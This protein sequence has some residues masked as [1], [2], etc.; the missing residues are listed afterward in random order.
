MRYDFDRITDRRG[1][2]SV[3]WDRLGP[4]FGGQDVL[5]MWVADMDFPCPEPVIEA[6]RRRLEHPVLGYGFAPDSLYQ[7]IID[8]MRRWYGWTVEKDWIVFTPGVIAALH[9]AIRTVADP[10][11]EIVLQPPV[12]YPFFRAV[13]NAGCQLVMNRLR[14]GDNGYAMDYEA[15][16]R[17]F[18][19][20]AT[21]PGRS[22][23]IRG[24][25]LCSPHN[26][27]GRAWRPDELRRLG[28][29]CLDH[30]CV[31][32]S[33]EIHCD[34]LIGAGS[35]GAGGRP[36][37]TP[38]AT[39]SP[40]LARRTIT[41]MAPSKSF[42]LAGLDASFTIIPDPELRR[43]FGRARLG[44]GG[45]NVLG[46][47]AMEAALRDGDDYLE[48]LNDYLTGNVRRFA[49]GIAQVS[50]MRL[51]PDQ[52][53][54]GTYLAWV[55]LRQLGDR[56]LGAGDSGAAEPAARTEASEPDAPSARDRALWDFMLRRA[57]VASDPGYIFG[58]GGEGFQR[59]NLACPRSVVDEAITRLN[60]STPTGR[61]R[62]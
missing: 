46:L 24:L 42:N 13:K 8:R 40:E 18:E 54:E 55:D 1:T 31:I 28:Q 43:R 22:H 49:E 61:Q 59:F 48:Q 30:D 35:G 37:H 27:V 34:L 57:R 56:L 6:L 58:P 12:Y 62:R 51:V 50:G 32:I 47:V 52:G 39:L 4:L 33:D 23:R 26:P 10:G 5:P 16:A 7:V 14:L 2:N 38:T 9:A 11:D 21:F 53:P 36:Q 44:Q 25:I 20:A 29:I 45:V 19:T 15:L 41:L 60:Q 3:K 17:G